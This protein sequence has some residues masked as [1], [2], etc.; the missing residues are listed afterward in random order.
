M[1][2]SRALALFTLLTLTAL[3]AGPARA[4]R[5]AAGP[6]AAAAM[7][8]YLAAAHRLQ[9]FSGTVLVARG[10]AVVLKKAYGQANYELGVANTVKTKFRLGSVTKQFT[11]MA[12]LQLE[13]SGKLKVT[14]TIKTFFP[15]Y[16]AGDTITIH[17]LLTHTSGI[18][19]LT[20]FPDYLKTMALPSPVLETVARF[21][22]KPLDFRPGEKFSYS[23]SGY[24]LLGAIIEKV[25]GAPYEAYVR[26]HIFKPLGMEDSGYDHAAPIL[27]DRAAGYEFD[28]DV[29]VN[30]SSIDM[31]VPHAAGALYST[32]DDLYKWDRA[33]YTDRLI[34]KADMARMFTPFKGGYAYGWMTGTLDGH[35]NIRHSGGINGFTC[36]VSRFPDDDAV[37]IVL[38]NFSTGFAQEIN[39][40]L[41]KILFGQTVEPPKEKTV[42]QVPAAVLDVYRGQYQLEGTPVIFTVTHEGDGLFVQVPNQP[43]VR[44]LAES[45]TKFFLKAVGFEVT[46]VKDAAGRVT[47]F[48]LLQGKRETK[49]VKVG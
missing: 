11:S 22:N 3:A 40:A 8:A 44:L 16:P 13:E 27:K 21:K 29:M 19:N 34:T 7:D 38:N 49:A 31:S 30:A 20:E 24:I 25:T 41:A 15:D 26:E 42:V 9:R 45:E 6:D 39:D 36:D 46:F 18:P 12:I 28:A 47:H 23:N 4:L 32:V 35:K 43:K 17:H 14:D 33:L 48:V 1:R 5:P 37:V 2:R 10:G